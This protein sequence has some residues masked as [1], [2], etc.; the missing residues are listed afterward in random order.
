MFCLYHAGGKTKVEAYLAAGY[1]DRGKKNTICSAAS[2]LSVQPQIKERIEE[3]FDENCKREE[4]YALRRSQ[5]VST[6]LFIRRMRRNAEKCVEKGDEL[7]ER[8][9]WAQIARAAGLYKDV[10][11]HQGDVHFH[12]RNE[13]AP[14]DPN[15]KELVDDGDDDQEGRKGRGD[16]EGG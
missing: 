3:I 5:K 13:L 2:R 4:D 8:N 15:R 7:G 14:N 11:G 12:F 9:A 6:D 10:D 16:G 1:S